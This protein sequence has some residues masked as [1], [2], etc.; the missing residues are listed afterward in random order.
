MHCVLALNFMDRG[1]WTLRCHCC[2]RTFEVE[3]K[4]TE[5]IIQYAQR[6]P[7]PHCN[8]KPAE[9]KGSPTLWHHIIAFRA[10]TPKLGH[11]LSEAPTVR[12]G[13]QMDVTTA[14]AVL[15][16]AL[17]RCDRKDMRTP[18]VFAALDF[19]AAQATVKWPFNQFRNALNGDGSKGWEREGRWQ[20]L[21]ASLNGITLVVGQKK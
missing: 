17:D 11:G 12:T 16:D 8:T 18:K 21:N 3:L 20:M 6:T 14:V 13:Q 1:T 15:Q 4:P 10:M 9:A 19:L 7:C 2:N 5:R